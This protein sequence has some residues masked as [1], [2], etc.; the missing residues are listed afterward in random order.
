MEIFLIFGMIG[1]LCIITFVSCKS[2]RINSK[3]ITSV[4]ENNKCTCGSSCSIRCDTGEY[5]GNENSIYVE[6]TCNNENCKTIKKR[7]NYFY[8]D[9]T[10]KLFKKLHE[11]KTKENIH[12]FTID[13]LWTINIPK[14]KWCVIFHMP[15]EDGSPDIT[16]PF[17]S[18]EEA[19]LFIE[20]WGEKREAYIEQYLKENQNKDIDDIPSGPCLIAKKLEFSKSNQDLINEIRK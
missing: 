10:D 5:Y 11:L 7:Y 15:W 19:K 2:G 1:I 14:E 8:C 6:F 4:I 20:K 12:R 17:D 9:S 18:K 13:R 3:F 16:G